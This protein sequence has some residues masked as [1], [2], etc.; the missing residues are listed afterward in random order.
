MRSI[1]E[2]PARNLRSSFRGASRSVRQLTMNVNR[3]PAPS[4]PIA[5]PIE[6]VSCQVRRHS[7]GVMKEFLATRGVGLGWT[8]SCQI[9]TAGMLGDD[10]HP[11]EWWCRQEQHC[12]GDPVTVALSGRYRYITWMQ[13]NNKAHCLHEE[14]KTDLFESGV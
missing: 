7:L 4:R 2:Q 11:C 8:G 6:L 13:R 9:A 5:N 14:R 1:P 10:C 12:D 3:C